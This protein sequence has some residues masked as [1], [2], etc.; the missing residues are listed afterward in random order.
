MG[1]FVKQF[2]PEHGI[3]Y[4]AI[5]DNFDSE[6]DNVMAPFQF[7]M[8]E[9]Y[10]RD[11]SR[12]VKEVLK[13]KREKGA[14]RASDIWNYTTVKRILKNRVYLGDTLLG[15]S[16]KVSVK[17]KMKIALPKRA[18]PKSAALFLLRQVSYRPFS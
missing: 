13:A 6:R 17:S 16:K 18:L 15:K 10:L 4:I 9:V 5:N 1:R 11:G 3:H 8:N 14:A 12:K 2:F 7:A